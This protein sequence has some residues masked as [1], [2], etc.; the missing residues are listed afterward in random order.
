[1]ESKQTLSKNAITDL[2]K[3][4]YRLH[5]LNIEKQSGYNN[6]TYLVWNNSQGSSETTR[7][8]GKYIVK[9]FRGDFSEGRS[10]SMRKEI[11]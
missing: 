2:L 3:K 6:Q 9:V 11:H 7:R 4:N 8:G 10:L 5:L 1:M